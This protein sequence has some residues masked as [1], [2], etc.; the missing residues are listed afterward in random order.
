MLI[1]LLGCTP[2]PP[3]AKKKPRDGEAALVDWAPVP[4]PLAAADR[5]AM[6]DAIRRVDAAAASRPLP[7]LGGGAPAPDIAIVV[8]DTV[9][10]DHLG[11]YGYDRDTSPRLDAWAQGATVF[12]RAY[13][14]GPWTLPAHASMFTGLPAR[15]H[16]ARSVGLD[17][18]RKGAP[19]A[20]SFYT[21][22]ERLRD[23]GY[24]TLGLAGN[25]AFLD[26]AYGLSQ[27]FDAWLCET[28]AEDSRGLGYNAADR[29]LP[30]ATTAAASARRPTLLFLNFMDAH[31]PYKPRRGYVKDPSK[32]VRKVIPGNK[33]ARKVVTSLLKGGALDPRVQ[34]SWVEAYD[35]EIRFLDEHLGTLF[36]ELSAFEYVFVLADH[37]EYLGEH[38]LVEHAKDVYEPVIHVPFMVKG[39]GYTPGRD[40]RMVQSHDLAWMVLEA[41]GLPVPPEVERTGEFAV[42]ELHYTLKKDLT[43]KDYGARFNR[44][45]RAL[46][47]G[48]HKLI[49]GSDGSRESYD[50]GVDPGELR[51]GAA[52]EPPLDPLDAAW[53]AAHPETP[54]VPVGA[55][56]PEPSDEQLRALGYVE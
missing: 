2:D 7:T 44:V 29:L 11:T 33:G 6:A 53:T 13:A 28:L 22:P 34:G 27:G 14:D 15:T 50:L 54:L 26:P 56:A 12:T 5:T 20:E 9:R 17:D 49:V 43:N 55:S 24:R 21:V 8:L 41:A 19:L 35:S 31:T 18:P 4:L 10:A 16:A 30:M 45:R 36:E 40:N 47:A 39:P 46:V 25:R 37:G 23:A 52:L 3:A 1:L 48:E 51:P 32:L 38:G 42:S